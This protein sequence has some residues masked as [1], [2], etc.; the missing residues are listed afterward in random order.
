MLELK[1]KLTNFQIREIFRFFV[2]TRRIKKKVNGEINRRTDNHRRSIPQ[3]KGRDKRGTIAR[4]TETKRK[5]QNDRILG[6]FRLWSK[7]RKEL[8]ERAEDK[9]ARSKDRWVDGSNGRIREKDYI[10]LIKAINRGGNER[11]IEA[12]DQ[13]H[14]RLPSLLVT[15]V[16]R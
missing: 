14:R 12:I 13:I 15:R 1:E 16:P 8:A 10:I 5:E 9:V 2:S 3:R 6:C 7:V 11:K 4:A